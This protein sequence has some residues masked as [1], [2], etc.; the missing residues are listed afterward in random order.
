[1][2]RSFD[3]SITNNKQLVYKTSL[4]CERQVDGALSFLPDHDKLRGLRRQGAAW[5]GKVPSRFKTFTPVTR[6]DSIYELN[7]GLFTL[8]DILFASSTKLDF[9]RLPG[10]FAERKESEWTQIDSDIM[11]VDFTMDLDLNL[12]YLL[13]TRHHSR[14]SASTPAWCTRSC[15]VYAE[16]PYEWI[17]L[18]ISGYELTLA[19]WGGVMAPMSNCHF[20]T[21]SALTA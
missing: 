4:I 16:E 20:Y 9:L 1:M 19:V 18:A 3:H 10:V 8:G 21:L 6:S 5:R 17:S 2:D 14:E 11:L 12:W 13:R 15:M 7:C